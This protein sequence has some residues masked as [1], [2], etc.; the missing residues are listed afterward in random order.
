MKKNN[1]KIISIGLI[2]GLINGLFGS[3]GGTIIVP[4]MIF[5]LGID[6]HKAHATAI[7][8]ILPLTIIS[9]IIYYRQNIIKYD[10][11]FTVAIGGIAGSFIGSNLLNKVPTNILRKIFGSFMIFAAIRLLMK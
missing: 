7:A 1:L 10:V 8:V 5:L 6:D 11:A 9:T 2:T 3:G 4:T